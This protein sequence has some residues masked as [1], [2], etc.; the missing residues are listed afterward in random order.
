[1]IKAKPNEH[2]GILIRVFSKSLKICP[3]FSA[4]RL[5]SDAWMMPQTQSG[6]EPAAGGMDRAKNY[7]E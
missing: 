3:M 4:P 1:M 7:F 6:R 5:G 2:R